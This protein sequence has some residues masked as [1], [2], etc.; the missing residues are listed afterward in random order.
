MGLIDSN[1]KKST[2]V[3]YMN[4]FLYDDRNYKNNSWFLRHISEV[5]V[6]EYWS[7]FLTELAGPLLNA[8]KAIHRQEQELAT[9]YALDITWKSLNKHEI[10]SGRTSIWNWIS[11]NVERYFWEVFF[12]N[13]YL[14]F[15]CVN[16]ELSWIKSWKVH[17]IYKT[18]VANK[19]QKLYFQVWMRGTM[20]VLI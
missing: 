3:H 4:L 2:F 1:V 5:R 6:S 14:T 12:L 10:K 13:D 20:C 15:E 9:R 19:I 16:N 11:V 8:S 18:E 17:Y 7:E